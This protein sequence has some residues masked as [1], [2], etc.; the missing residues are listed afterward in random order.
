M[1]IDDT[2]KPL[3]VEIFKLIGV[4][5]E[6]GTAWTTETIA[7]YLA[8][9]KRLAFALLIASLCDAIVFWV[10][11]ALNSQMV[12]TIS[13]MAFSIM[14]MALLMFAAPLLVGITAFAEKYPSLRF[15]INLQA[16]VALFFLI[17]GLVI[18]IHPVSG[19]NVMVIIVGSMSLSLIWFLTGTK[20][21]LT[22]L[23]T[24]IIFLIAFTII[25]PGLTQQ[26]PQI[27][28]T[29]KNLLRDL[30]EVGAIFFQIKPE[31]IPIDSLTQFR[32]MNFF[33]PDGTAKVY[34]TVNEN[35][36]EYE[37]FDRKGAHPIYSSKLKPVTPEIVKAIEKRLKSSEILLRNPERIPI[38]SLAQFRSIRFFNSDG[39]AKIYYAFNENNSEYEVFD[40]MG[41]HPTYNM[42]LKPVTPEIVKSI[43][44][45][46][47]NVG[48]RNV[49][50]DPV[51]PSLETPIPVTSISNSGTLPNI[52]IGKVSAPPLAIESTET[53][54]VKLTIYNQNYRAQDFYVEDTKMGTIP[55]EKS[56]FYTFQPGNYSV[57]FCMSGTSECGDT[58]KV[59]WHSGVNTLWLQKIPQSSGG[60]DMKF[61]ERPNGIDNEKIVTAGRYLDS[62]GCLREANGSFVIG[63][64]SDCK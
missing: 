58:S 57:H 51:P 64:K 50:V 47:I 55:A 10:A 61:N 23:K 26:F 22:F 48:K 2:R 3:L 30:D 21:D 25:G 4:I 19:K 62:N 28:I 13:L 35:N 6:G 38:D 44:N 32:A 9:L 33:N 31:R 41:V 34:Y 1:T 29:L 60:A 8:S 39:T 16:S 11:S 20:P 52:G 49:S 37:V 7:S 46:L 54:P 15:F 17:I 40:R 5:V 12:M 42:K 43:E 18:N 24:K 36:G 14:L 53:E 45:R 27:N 59:H 56:K 63:F